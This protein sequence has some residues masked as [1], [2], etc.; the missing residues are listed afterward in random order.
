MSILTHYLQAHNAYLLAANGSCVSMTILDPLGAGRKPAIEWMVNKLLL[1]SFFFIG[2]HLW[3]SGATDNPFPSIPPF[4]L[5]P[6]PALAY[7]PNSPDTLSLGQSRC[8]QSL[9]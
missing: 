1:G 2:N 3:P 4:S 9:Y 7:E 5:L 6:I 8:Y